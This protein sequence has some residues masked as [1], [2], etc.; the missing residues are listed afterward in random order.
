MKAV[1]LAAGLGTRI[2]PLS[3]TTPKP[4][5]PIINRPVMEFLVELLKSH[6]FDQIIVSTSYLANDI[7]HYFRDGSRFGVEMAYSFEGYHA[8]GRVVPEGLGAAGGLKKIQEQSGFFD[9]TFAVVCGDAIVD[10]DFTQALR[11]HRT[12][13]AI[14]TMLLKDVAR[15]EVNRYGVVQTAADGR[16]LRFHEKPAPEQAITTTVNAGIYMFEPDALD[17]IPANQPYDIALQFFPRLIERGLPLFGV[18]LP[19]TWIDIGCIPDYWRATRLILEGGLPAARFSGREI[20]PRVWSGINVAVNLARVTIHGPVSI[21][22][23]TKI[24][25]GATIIGPAVIGRNS[26]IESGAYVESSVIG[27]YTRISGL[28]HLHEKIVS[29]RFCVGCDGRSVDLAG[30]GYAFVVDDVRERRQWTE[31]QQTLIDFLRTHQ[32]AGI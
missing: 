16:I 30:A 17:H 22:S 8:D 5:I 23:S 31:D 1:I 32:L 7:E 24:E 28:A 21:G 25:D 19:F 13:G 10:V 4:M 2:R 14:A 6:G 27:D 9:D 3:E 29:G 18:A 11:F 26:I 15:A 20:A 12:R